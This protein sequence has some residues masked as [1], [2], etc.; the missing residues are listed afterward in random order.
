MIVAMVNE[1]GVF[2]FK[3]EGE[4]PVAADR[5]RPVAFQISMERMRSPAG[6][7]HVL[8]RPGI[9]ESEKLFAQAL[10][11]TGLNFRFRPSSEEQFDS[12]MAK[13]LY[14]PYSV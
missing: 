5:H 9:V 12:L 1:N 11:M 8:Q 7:I 14:H 13:A 10:T 2:T 6:S 4:S 3:R